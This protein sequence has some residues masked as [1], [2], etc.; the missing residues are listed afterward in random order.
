MAELDRARYK[1]LIEDHILDLLPEIDHKSIALYDA[2]KYSL[3]AGG[4]R[5]RP[6][7]LL[8]ACEFAGGKWKQHCHTLV[9]LNIFILIP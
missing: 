6:I 2:M 8:A 1:H 5:V 9:P 7:L 4:K 3:T